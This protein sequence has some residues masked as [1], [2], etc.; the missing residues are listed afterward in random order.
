MNLI[1]DI[2]NTSVK[3]ALFEGKELILTERSDA[4]DAKV[5]IATLLAFYKIDSA[6]ISSVAAEPSDI[7]AQLHEKSCFVHQLTR[8]SKFPFTSEYK[9]PETI[10][11][12]R[13]AA[14]AG[15]VSL[16]GEANMLII[17]AGSAVTFDVVTGSV[18][19]GGSISPGMEMR[20]KALHTFT[21]RLPLCSFTEDLKFPA[22]GTHEA[23]TTG[24]IQGLIFE[25]N[26]YIR[27]FKSD[28]SNP[29]VILTGGDS[30]LLGEF[31]KYEF[32]PLPNL[33]IEGLNFLLEFNRE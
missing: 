28:N 1:I 19:R 15:A 2:G 30:L 3:T 22:T 12:D 9:T 32:I 14:A 4:G 6:I 25:L 33:V 5:K 7:I 16:F 13:L 27:T 8:K 17:D 20:F 29:V 31:V 21:G 24:V 18:F 26:E 10:G 11:V 23:I